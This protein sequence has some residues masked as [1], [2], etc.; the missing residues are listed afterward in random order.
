MALL[1][2]LGFSVCGPLQNSSF[3]AIPLA[4]MW[5]RR[6]AVPEV[7]SL[8]LVR[9]LWLL[10]SPTRLGTNDEIAPKGLIFSTTLYQKCGTEL[11][12]RKRY[13]TL[14]VTRVSVWGLAAK[15]RKRKDKLRMFGRTYDVIS[16]PNVSMDYEQRAIN[17]F[18]WPWDL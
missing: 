18:E 4:S 14:P 7:K 16:P 8:G 12:T 17:D 5:M 1:A 13:G 2:T 3:C 11:E 15:H 6:G 9:S 10:A